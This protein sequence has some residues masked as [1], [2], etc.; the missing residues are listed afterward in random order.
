MGQFPWLGI[1]ETN[2]GNLLCTVSIL[3]EYWVLT[4]GQKNINDY[5]YQVK[6]GVHDRSFDESFTK[7]L[8]LTKVVQSGNSDRDIALVQM[9]TLIERIFLRFSEGTKMEPS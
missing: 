2:E 9:E 3:D 8:K 4:S 1:L 5:T 7:L 6:V